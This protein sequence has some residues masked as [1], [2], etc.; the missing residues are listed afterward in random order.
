MNFIIVWIFGIAGA[1]IL[2]IIIIILILFKKSQ[3]CK[4]RSEPDEPL[5][6][7]GQN[8]ICSKLL[9]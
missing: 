1:V 4:R 9:V 8:S 5:N 2:I 7:Q 6:G 3:I